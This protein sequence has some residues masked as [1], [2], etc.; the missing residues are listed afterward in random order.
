ML[1]LLL[2]T[3]IGYNVRDRLEYHGIRLIDKIMSYYDNYIGIYV[4]RALSFV[5]NLF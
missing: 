1:C 5:I 4:H 3:N 2:N